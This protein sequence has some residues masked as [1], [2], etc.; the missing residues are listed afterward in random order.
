MLDD[1]AIAGVLQRHDALADAGAALIADAN[2]AGGKDNIAV[3]LAR[4]RHDAGAMR[5]WW[6]FGR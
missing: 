4:P 2:G 3:I 5:S 6:P 1:A